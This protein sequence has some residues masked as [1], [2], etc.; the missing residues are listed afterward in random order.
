MLP[1]LITGL[2]LTG[3]TQDKQETLTVAYQFGTAYAPVELLRVEGK[4]E[5]TLGIPVKWV[6]LQNTATIR[7][8]MLAGETDIGFMAIPPFLIGYDGGTDWKIITGLSSMPSGL[9]TREDITDLSEIDE[10]ARIALPQPGSVQHIL[11]AMAA[12]KRFNDA[13]RFDNRLVALSH[14]D[15]MN[16]LLSGGDINYHF[17]TAPYLQAELDTGMTL[18]LSGREAFGGEFTGIVGVA[19]SE[20]LKGRADVCAAFLKE[21]E[22]AS[23]VISQDPAYAAK[24]L[25]PVYAIEE[26]RL[27]EELTADGAAFVTSVSGVEEF[28]GFMFR[29]GYIKTLPESGDMIFERP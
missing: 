26:A 18:L 27:F 7:E 13:G 28:A 25:A 20:F 14:P 1:L 21:L 6:Q 15:G 2:L 9:V 24:V 19:Q 16:L 3:C 22:A 17:T 11:L 8:S 23:L 5:E 10:N 12:E 29:T 4:L